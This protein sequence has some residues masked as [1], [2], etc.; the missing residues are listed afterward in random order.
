MLPSFLPYIKISKEKIFVIA[1]FFVLVARNSIYAQ[2]SAQSST[3]NPKTENVE[4]YEVLYEDTNTGQLFTK[5]GPNR[6]RVEYLRPLPQ[7]TRTTLPD[8][9]AH[10][11]NDTS[12]EKLTLYARMQ[13]RGVSGSADSTFGNGV[14]D[15][16]AVD[17]AFRRLR[18]GTMYE[19][20]WW[21]TNIQLRLENMLNR[22]DV[23]Q[24]T[25]TLNYTDSNGRPASAT[26]VSNVRMRDNRGYIHE[27]N[28][29]TKIPF[30]GLRLI[31]GQIPT[32]FSREFLHNAAS[33]VTLERSLIV[34][35]IPQFDQG[36]MLFT[37]PLKELG[38]KWESYL[39]VT[40]MVGNG[41]GGGGDYGTGR[42][43]DLTSSNRYGAVNISPIYFTRVQ[44]N[45]FGGLKRESDGKLLNWQEG[46]EIFQRELKWSVG[47]GHLQTQNL[48]T[49][50]VSVVEFT[51]GTT[52]G[53]Q[54]LTS[55]GSNPDRG[56]VDANG[57]PNFLVQ[58]SVPTLGRP[59]MGLVGHTYDSTLTYK[60]FYFSTAYTK[61]AGAASN[62]L[63]GY[64]GT[65]GYNVPFLEKYYIM[66]VM[67]YEYI[68]G[69]FNR[70]AKVDPTDS[71]RVYWA[72]LNFFG[73]KH[74][75]KAQLYYQ[76]LGNQ[77]DVNPNTGNAMPIDDRR[78][79]F[80]LQA[81][82]WTGLVSPEAY[83]YRPL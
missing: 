11:P 53:I 54:L 62:D 44:A 35:A 27:A 32:Q 7:G 58:N 73:D 33:F 17:W 12:D 79:Y 4:T 57:L 22:P 69:D 47:I 18:I 29:Y 25:N 81:N 52:S 59:K 63:F 41:K 20:D 76:I 28:I 75:F 60:G 66:P 70:N 24:T 16:N 40:F 43:Q 14:R 34:T 61:F 5:P 55:Q 8:T 50:G 45:I 49:P 78:I 2:S 38:N 74:H 21:G 10:R 46:E 77:F 36:V 80:Q 13:F 48:I 1:I 64:H 30:A 67:K 68:Q 51:P 19:N 72:G 42:R 31:M 15:Y 83:S 65:I 71:L 37:T 3:S 6:K 9:F 26:Y 23:V 56:G 39:Q 82:F